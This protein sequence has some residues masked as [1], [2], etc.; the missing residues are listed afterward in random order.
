MPL[1]RC[2]I[3]S[4]RFPS[5]GGAHTLNRANP[6]YRGARPFDATHGA[7]YRA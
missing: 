4:V 1:L 3:A 5:D 6:G 7:S 2:D